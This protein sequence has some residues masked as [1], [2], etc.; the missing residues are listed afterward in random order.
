MYPSSFDSQVICFLHSHISQDQANHLLN[1]FRFLKLKPKSALTLFNI[2]VKNQLQPIVL[3]KILQWPG[4]VFRFR[5]DHHPACAALRSALPVGRGPWTS[6]GGPR[7]TPIGRSHWGTWWCKIGGYCLL[8]ITCIFSDFWVSCLNNSFFF[9]TVNISGN[10]WDIDMWYRFCEPQPF[11][12]FIFIYDKLQVLP[13]LQWYIICKGWSLNVL[14]HRWADN[15]ITFN[16]R[17]LLFF[18]ISISSSTT[19]F[20]S[21]FEGQL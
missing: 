6:V 13:T 17:F 15:C 7:P 3:I 10:L 18:S 19:S 5:L 1:K 12:S 8:G 2:R 4:A 21:E 16:P 11:V 14:I 9:L 20:V